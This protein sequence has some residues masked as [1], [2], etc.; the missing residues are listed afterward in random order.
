MLG[1][2]QRNTDSIGSIPNFFRQDKPMIGLKT[3][4]G[5]NPLRVDRTGDASRTRVSV[6]RKTTGRGGQITVGWN[7]TDSPQI[8]DSRRVINAEQ[9]VSQ[10]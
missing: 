4:L 8:Q 9:E 5:G 3:A 10:P 2:G 6:T 1:R 7:R